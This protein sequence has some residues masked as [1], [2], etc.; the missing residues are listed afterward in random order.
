MKMLY[1]F[2]GGRMD[3]QRLERE[4]VL[5]IASGDT[6]YMGRERAMGALVR[7]EELDGQPTVK[8]YVGPMWDGLRYEIDGQTFYDFEVS[9]DEKKNGSPSR[10]LDTRPSGSTTSCRIER[11]ETP[12]QKTCRTL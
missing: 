9:E 12:W 5:R 7:R 1:E 10:S 3:G 2:I 8:G 6:G 4:A 11:R